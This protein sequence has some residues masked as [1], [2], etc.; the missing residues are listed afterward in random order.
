MDA[1]DVVSLFYFLM[2]FM[3]LIIMMLMTSHATFASIIFACT[4][5]IITSVLLYM[6]IRLSQRIRPVQVADRT[7]SPYPMIGGICTVLDEITPTK[8]GYVRFRGEL[9][10]AFSVKSNFKRGDY[11]YVVDVRGR[12][13]II[14]REPLLMKEK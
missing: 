13:L 1:M 3:F 4:S 2:F 11:A 8:D 10:R 7:E 12:F 6:I 14:E 5:L 9:W